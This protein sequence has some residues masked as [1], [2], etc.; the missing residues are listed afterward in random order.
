MGLEHR[1]PTA[2]ITLTELKSK[3]GEAHVW[4]VRGKRRCVHSFIKHFLCSGHFLS[5]CLFSKALQ[6]FATVRLEVLMALQG[7]I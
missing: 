5:S 1:T 3:S 6:V 4:I 2:I 7:W